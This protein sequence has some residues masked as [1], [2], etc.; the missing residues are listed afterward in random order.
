MWVEELPNGKY[1][2][3]ERYKDT[4]TE[5]WKR[6]SVTLNSGSNRA[7]KEAQR[8]LDDKIAEKMAGLNT[9]DASFNDVLDEWWEFHKK[10]IRRTSISSM[11]SNVRYVAENFAIDVKIANIDTHYIQRFINDADIPRSILERV[12]SI[13]N[14]T[15]DYACTVGYIDSNP[16]RQAKLP[17]KQ[18]TMEDYDK[19][20]NK[21]LEIDTELLPLLSK[22]ALIEMPSLQSFSLSAV[23][24]LVKL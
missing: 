24:V 13:L 16:A 11:T 1:K 9:T 6:V 21:F 17:K 18:Q 7:K 8:L 19:I 22:N 12:K 2:Y 10:G 4:Y 15:F 14:L 5:K 23:P 3:F 20:R